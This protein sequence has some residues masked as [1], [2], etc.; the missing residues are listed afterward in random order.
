MTDEETQALQT[1]LET[2]KTELEGIKAEKEALT[3]ELD[4]TCK[5]LESFR[6]S[7]GAKEATITE[8][9]QVIAAKDSDI[10][11]LKQ[12]A[13]DSERSE[14]EAKQSLANAVSAYKTAVVQANPAVPGELLTGD[15][16]EAINQSLE[17]AKTLVA[18]VRQS[19]EADIAAGKVPAG[20]PARTPPDLSALSP[21]EKIQYAITKGGKK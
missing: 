17:S 6:D 10:V 20:A 19:L 3:S 11:T 14:E 16:I 18:Q 12:A 9:E 7:F 2:T 15:T 21:R 13:S 4:L 5:E 1:E 8:L